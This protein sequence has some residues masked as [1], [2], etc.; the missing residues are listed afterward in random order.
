MIELMKIPAGA[1]VEVLEEG[2]G[3]I[4]FLPDGTCEMAELRFT[5][6]EGWTVI[7]TSVPKI[8]LKIGLGGRI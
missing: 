7:R 2:C 3:V 4:A 8:E 1:K 6:T 5:F